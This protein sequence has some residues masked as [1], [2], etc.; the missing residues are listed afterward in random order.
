MKKEF[1]GSGRGVPEGGAAGEE[2][3]GS[4]GRN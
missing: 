4:S 3:K 2:R 1:S